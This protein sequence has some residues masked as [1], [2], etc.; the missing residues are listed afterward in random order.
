M[1]DS[2]LTSW[3]FLISPAGPK[4]LISTSAI[5]LKLADALSKLGSCDAEVNDLHSTSMLLIEITFYKKIVWEKSKTFEEMCNQYLAFL[6]NHYHHVIVFD[7]YP[8]HPTTKDE[9]YKRTAKKRDCTSPDI[10]F[11]SNTI[12]TIDKDIFLVNSLN[13]QNFL[14]TLR[15]HFQQNC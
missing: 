5:R 11:D 6:S 4:F 10:I 9:T 2:I 15:E 3:D 7:S 13:N 1:K 12:L 8:N 14:N